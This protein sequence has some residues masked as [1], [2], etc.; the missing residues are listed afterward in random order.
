MRTRPHQRHAVSVQIEG[1]DYVG[2]YYL[3]HDSI[4]VHYGNKGS[5]PTMI[6]AL[7]AAA[8]A[9]MLLRGAG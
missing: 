7:E 1:K 6:G 2:C 8:C 9:Q 4:T 3:D 5:K